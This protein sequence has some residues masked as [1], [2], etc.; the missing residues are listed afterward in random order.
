MLQGTM[1]LL[2]S[3]STEFNLI[4]E[5]K[6]FPRCLVIVSATFQGNSFMHT[7]SLCC[8][9]NSAKI[10]LHHSHNPSLWL[11]HFSLF[12]WYFQFLANIA[13]KS[14]NFVPIKAK[15]IPFLTSAGI[16]PSTEQTLKHINDQ[17]NSKA[18]LMQTTEQSPPELH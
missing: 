17:F 13:E 11:G 4:E 1:C 12:S 2:H 8:Q 10:L 6:S 18:F 16:Q 3:T 5:R 14:R 7:R 9:L 15:K